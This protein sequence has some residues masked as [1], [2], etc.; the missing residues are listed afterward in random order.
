[1]GRVNIKGLG[2]VD[3]EGNA[4]NEEEIA[5]FQKMIEAKASSQI[6]DAPAEELTESF[7]SSPSFGRLLTEAGLAIAG[8]IATGGLALPGLALRAGMLARPFL[9]Q[10]AKSS[11]GAGV[12][13]GTGAA[14]AQTFDPKEDV[15]KEILRAT[16]EGALAEAVGAPL[17]IKGAQ[18]AGKFLGSSNPKAFDDLLD[19]AKNAEFALQSKGVQILKGLKPDDFAKL[20]PEE[21]KKILKEI[22]SKGFVA[23]QQTVTQFAEAAGLKT[24][25]KKI[26]GLEKTAIEIAQGLTPGVKSS[27]RTLEIIENIAQKS[28]VGGGAITTRYQAAKEVGDIIARDVLQ[29]FQ[30]GAAVGEAEIGRLFLESLGG[31]EGAF[32]VTKN[33]LYKAVDDILINKGALNNQVIPVNT[34][35]N[36]VD[37]IRRFYT[38]SPA[39]E[40]LGSRVASI[41]KNFD[42]RTGKYS[43][44]QLDKLRKGLQDDFARLPDARSRQFNGKLIETVDQILADPKLSQL[45]PKEAVDALNLANKFN[46]EGNDIF[47]RGITN[48]LLKKAGEDG[49]VLSKDAK[50][51]QQ[52]FKQVAGQDNIMTAKAM[53][54]EIDALTGKN[55]AES[56]GFEALTKMIDPVTKKPMLTVAQGQKLKDS[57]RGHYL[58]NAMRKAEKGSK[59][60]GKYIDSD[61]F[62]KSID[63]GEGKLRKFLFQGDDAKKLEELQ[64]TLAFAQGD[65]SRLPGIP[66][67][68][69]IQ[70]KQAGAAGTI[71]SLGGVGGTAVGAGL[72]GGF[73]PAAGILL[74][75][76]VASKIMLNPK[77]S[78]LIFKES[79]K[80][81]AKGENTPSKM[82]VLYRQIIGRM[83][84][85]GVISKE[86]RDDAIRQVDNF[87]KKSNIQAASKI[88]QPNLPN[89]KQSNFPVIAGGTS[90]M[91]TAVG[92]GS[93][94]ELAQALNLF[95]KGGIVSAKKNF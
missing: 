19:G 79:A 83:L 76:A 26:K 75:P 57:V 24:S 38:E 3:I 2:V 81:V 55:V 48:T 63:E 68:I 90:P 37:D 49:L 15:I 58:A 44:S 85:D 43:F 21:Q 88:N 25:A 67:G 86:E 62:S 6:T 94:T 56:D 70:L 27:N 7:M 1:M 64:N 39:P 89:V 11:V 16:T 31:A 72:L 41:I 4:P 50:A 5:V 22:T 8:S 45:I 78:N 54:R 30:Q 52:V 60:F 82:A 69:F 42:E 92:G 95:N 87:E 91:N 32:K 46:R 18:V 73:V 17:V 12:G 71:L 47:T 59:Q 23:D 29:E 84:T 61:A 65:L 53:F 74:A 40:V 51:V 14:V 66:G 35:R 33:K 13:G 34:L 28:I 20:K 93:N 80:I 10:L 9:T 77:F 36:T